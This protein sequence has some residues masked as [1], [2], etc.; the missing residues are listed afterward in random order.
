MYKNDLQ[1]DS[2]N[3]SRKTNKQN[4]IACALEKLENR[5]EYWPRQT[6]TFCVCF[7]F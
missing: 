5:D 7:I 3:F 6:N 1:N 2:Y 4:L